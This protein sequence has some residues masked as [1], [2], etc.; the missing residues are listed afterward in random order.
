MKKKYYLIILL[1]LALSS[2]SITD[3]FYKKTY[4]YKNVTGSIETT[5]T[6]LLKKKKD[7]YHITRTNNEGQRRE[8]NQRGEVRSHPERFDQGVLQAGEASEEEETERL[9]QEVLRGPR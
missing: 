6:W 2:F 1:F 4:I 5:S 9:A 3:V 8:A 7:N